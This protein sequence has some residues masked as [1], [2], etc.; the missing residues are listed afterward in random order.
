MRS[1]P[2]ARPSTSAP[3]GFQPTCPSATAP[4]SSPR[5]R[6]PESSTGTM[7]TESATTRRTSTPR[8][9]ATRSAREK[10]GRAAGPAKRSGKGLRL[11]PF[12]RAELHFDARHL[13]SHRF[14][15]GPRRLGP[16]HGLFVRRGVAVLRRPGRQGR[17]S[18]PEL[19]RSRIPPLDQLLFLF[20][21]CFSF[22][23]RG[24][25]YRSA[26]LLSRNW[27]SGRATSTLQPEMPRI[28]FSGDRMK[29][30]RSPGL[31]IPSR[32]YYATGLMLTA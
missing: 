5:V 11:V 2:A 27:L 1:K 7:K 30:A 22:V 18:V 8:F 29:K 3:A 10:A 12:S 21:P 23:H 32:R 24:K 14:E 4:T 20:P 13:F 17:L 28:P 15:L 25:G 26:H 6:S 19:T 16:E 9:A 31:F